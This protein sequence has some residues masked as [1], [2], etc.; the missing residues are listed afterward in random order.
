LSPSAS[1]E[2]DT[3]AEPTDEEELRDKTRGEI[4]VLILVTGLIM[5]PLF[6]FWQTAITNIA[7]IA[8]PI[9]QN[10]LQT[11]LGAPPYSFNQMI[12]AYFS[13]FGLLAILPV[14]IFLWIYDI[15]VMLGIITLMIFGFALMEIESGDAKRVRALAQKGRTCLNTVLLL[16]I[17]FVIFHILNWTMLP[18]KPLLQ[19]FQLWIMFGIALLTAIAVN[20]FLNMYMKKVVHVSSF[21]LLQKKTKSPKVD[22]KIPQVE[23]EEA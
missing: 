3:E 5:T 2:A 1:K 20:R 19:P 12:A 14:D 21:P 6:Y 11:Q 18:F 23:S 15:T 9:W 22:S 17:A 10:Y 16:L 8:V 13:P 7:N 4:E